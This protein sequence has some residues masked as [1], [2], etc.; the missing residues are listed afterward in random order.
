MVRT[1]RKA[2]IGGLGVL[3]TWMVFSL[4]AMAFLGRAE[5][6][7]AWRLE[8]V[9]V[10]MRHGVRPPT[11][12]RVVPEGFTQ[13][14]WPSWDVDWGYL[15]GHGAKAIA[16]LGELDARSYGAFLGEDCHNIRV[17][18]DIDQRTLKTAEAY[19]QALEPKCPVTVE[20]GPM[21]QADPRFSPFEADTPADGE[22]M[23]A[24]AQGALGSGGLAAL[25]A[26]YA[27]LLKKL[28][29]I[30]GCCSAPACPDGAASCG[31]EDMPTRFVDKK[32]RVKIDGGLD[33]A[34]SLAQVLLLQYADAKPLD[35]V[36][37][38]LADRQTIADLSA[39][40]ALEF[41][42]VA[43]PKAI[44]D[45]GA[46]PLLAE[47][48]RGLFATDTKKMTVLVGHDSNLAYVGGALDLH[49]KAGGLAPDSLA[50]DSLAKD[51]PA[52]GG[53]LIFEKWRNPK[54]REVVIVRYRAQSLDQMR[55]LT[56]LTPA[57]SHILPLSLCH[58]KT[59]CA[60]KRFETL[61]DRN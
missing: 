46:R 56:D 17:V 1:L 16:K 33:T 60:A 31:L 54:G 7:E 27:P 35:S 44:A 15:T 49:W 59:A 22:A 55:N 40:H 48:K 4:I 18:A 21:D 8:R 57:A 51:D 47:V 9:V 13:K 25:D 43:R 61:L 34:S 32:N 2:G 10:V 58:G 3:L 39:L 14:T 11:K 26:S 50:P 24:A 42:L 41:Q 5:A 30:L 45:F 37:W 29:A 20:H 53:A 12:A 23:L 38:G 52:P 19:A 6:S 28:D 36:G